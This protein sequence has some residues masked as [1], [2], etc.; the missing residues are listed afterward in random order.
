V[1]KPGG[2]EG[3]IT[4][5]EINRKL[6]LRPAKPVR[7]P[8][9]EFACIPRVSISGPGLSGK[10][11]VSLIRINTRGKGTITIVRTRE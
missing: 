1:V 11:V 2:T 8:V 4:L 7:H 10:T 6:L 3:C 5:D 9:G